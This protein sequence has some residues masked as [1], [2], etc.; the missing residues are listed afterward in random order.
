MSND[1]IALVSARSHYT[2]RARILEAEAQK[3]REAGNPLRARVIAYRAKIAQRA[4]MAELVNPE[5]PRA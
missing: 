2:A 1:S 5:V 3:E 4:A